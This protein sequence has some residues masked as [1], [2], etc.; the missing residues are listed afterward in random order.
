[1]L[2]MLH[3]PQDIAL[4][5]RCGT[6]LR[7]LPSRELAVA[8]SMGGLDRGWRIAPSV[9]SP[10]QCASVPCPQATVVL[11]LWD[12]S[13]F[14]CQLS[15]GASACRPGGRRSYDS[16]DYT[17]AWTR[18]K[19]HMKDGLGRGCQ[20]QTPVVYILATAHTFCTLYL[21]PTQDSPAQ[22]PMREAGLMGLHM[23][24]LNWMS[25]TLSSCGKMEMCVC[26]SGHLR[27]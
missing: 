5:V 17:L 27:M 24:Y 2:R 13:W 9:G 8:M 23:V 19:A 3:C 20:Y 12:C 6:S 18:G 16:R 25:E 7:H 10:M 4:G 26:G 21:F 14:M 22:L 1:M 11:A 15:L